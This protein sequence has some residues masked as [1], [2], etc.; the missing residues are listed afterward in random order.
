MTFTNSGTFRKT[1]GT[2]NTRFVGDAPFS[3]G[4][5]VDMQ[6]GALMFYGNGTNSGTFNMAGSAATYFEAGYTLKNG[7]A[8]TG[9]G[10]NYLDGGVIAINGGISFVNLALAGATITGTNTLNGTVT[11]SGGVFN[12]SVTT[13][14][15]LNNC[16]LSAGTTMTCRALS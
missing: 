14:P 12:N 15:P 2:G 4:G 1:A 13:I 5:L 10:T 16:I 6:S 9:A 7:S 8:F 11:W 3:N